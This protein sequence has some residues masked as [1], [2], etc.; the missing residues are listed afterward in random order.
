MSYA[1][2]G[3]E[4]ARCL[5]RFVKPG[6][7]LADA[8]PLPAPLEAIVGRDVDVTKAGLRSHLASLGVPEDAVGGSLDRPL[9]RTESGR[10][11]AYFVIHDTSTPNYRAGPFPAEIDSPEWAFAD[12]DR[13]KGDDTA[14]HLFIARDGHSLVTQDYSVPWR[15][16]KTE[17]CALLVP[18][19]GLFLHNEL[20]QPR[21]SD[22]PGSVGN[23]RLAPAPPLQAVTDAQL[24]RLALAYVA[25]SVRAGR[26][27]VPA[28]HAAIDEGLGDGHDDPQRFRLGDWA[29][30]VARVRDAA[31][32]AV[33]GR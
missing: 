32:V 29:G 33:P 25:A 24:D 13:W 14:A 22:P 12:L 9:S 11:A 15:G 1:G 17:S 16:T 18:S 31:R 20:V 23:D 5:L 19:R 27:L 3:V 21:R 7:H 28:F 10:S 8:A 4:Q 2:T 26:W 6:G 30:R